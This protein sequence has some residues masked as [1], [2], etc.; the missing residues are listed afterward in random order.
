MI[1]R[2]IPTNIITG[3]LGVGKTT[4]ITDLLQQ[5]PA[6]ERWA[7]LINEFGEIGIDGSVVESQQQ[8]DDIVI[9]EV[10]GGCMCCAAGLPMKVALN[11]L[12]QKA[13]PDRLL[14]EPTGLGHPKEVIA[15]LSRPE[16]RNVLALKATVTL[17]DA[18]HFGDPRYI[19][20]EIFRQQLQVADVI[21]ANKQ[22]CYNE[23]DRQHLERYLLEH[24][25]ATTPL[26]FSQQGHL[27]LQWLQ[28]ASQ[29]QQQSWQGKHEALLRQVDLSEQAL[30][31]QGYLRKSNASAGYFVC[32]W[33]FDRSFHF[34]KKLLIALCEVINAIRIKATLILAKGDYQLNQIE[35]ETQ[36]TKLLNT[37]LSESRIEI[38]S[39][40][41][42]DWPS[43]EK[44]LLKCVLTPNKL[45]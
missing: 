1:L 36:F 39:Q 38:I 30:P 35:S 5:K 37:D 8:A 9:T 24:D 2:P 33:R 34:D 18:R 25:L 43:I 44:Q 10:P 11:K 20:H 16:Y 23:L 40:T 3:F 31:E 21:A 28:Q 4:S 29:H 13:R 17:V 45:P 41:Q 6:S 27:D 19:D 12:I 32:G 15:V 26:Y 14:I 42:Q 22:D 7:V